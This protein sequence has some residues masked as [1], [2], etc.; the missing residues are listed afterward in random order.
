MSRTQEGSHLASR[1][2]R[3]VGAAIDGQ[4]HETFEELA[5]AIASWQ[6]PLCEGRRHMAA[7]TADTPWQQLPAVPV[8]LF[9]TLHIGSVPAQDGARCFQTSGTTQGVRGKHWMWD[10]SLYD[11]GALRWMRECVPNAPRTIIGLLDDPTHA[12]ESSL[13]HMVALFADAGQPASWHTR[14]GHLDHTTLRQRLADQRAP[15]FLA[16]TAFALAEWLKTS[17]PALPHGSV[18]MVTGGFKGRRHELTQDE[19][20]EATRRSLRPERLIT[21]YGMTELSSQLWGEPELPYRPPPWLRV[22][23]L[24]PVSGEPLLPGTAGQLRFVDLCNVDGALCIDTL[25]QGV[26]SD[27]GDVVLSGRLPGSDARGCSLTVEDAWER[28]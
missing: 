26:V 2:A 3:F 5:Y 16:A 24:D 9:K 8:D 4:P 11:L 14:D 17:P 28:P 19:L 13:S 10:T 6:H 15:I 18:V 27:A 25:D 21:E 20:Y 1:V 7:P 22:V 23:A 12:P